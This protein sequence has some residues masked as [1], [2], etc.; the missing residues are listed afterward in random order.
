[1]DLDV[2]DYGELIRFWLQR[3]TGEEGPIA[4]KLATTLGI[5]STAVGHM[6]RG[7]RTIRERHWKLIA[8][9]FGFSTV[10]ALIADAR[11]LW[12]DPDHRRYYVRATAA[13]AQQRGVSLI[14]RRH[15]R[16]PAAAVAR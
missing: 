13:P 3:R 10:D 11:R 4:P 2:D 15:R 5:T 7:T 14:R 8:D 6:I 16:T 12:A 1:M 9:H